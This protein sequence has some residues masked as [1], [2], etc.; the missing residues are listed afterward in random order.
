M[1]LPFPENKTGEDWDK[2]GLLGV[3]LG[4]M[5]EKLEEEIKQDLERLEGNQ[6]NESGGKSTELT[7]VER[8][9][10]TLLKLQRFR[11]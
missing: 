11:R 8:A 6:E 2:T 5:I 3:T 1:G 7:V 4:C 9:Y 10:I